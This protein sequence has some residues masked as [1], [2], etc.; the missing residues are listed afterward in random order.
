[1]RSKSILYFI[2][3]V[4]TMAVI[5]AFS[6][7]PLSESVKISNVIVKPVQSGVHT[8]VTAGDEN[9]GS[10]TETKNFNEIDNKIQKLV[11]KT[12]HIFIFGM[13]GMFVFLFFLSINM[14][15]PTAVISTLAFCLFY[16][17]SDEFH[18]H[19]VDSRNSNPRDVCIDMAG[20]LIAVILLCII[21]RIKK[22]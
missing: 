15:I 17:A 11:R 8:A 19:F 7:Q 3:S 4:V 22:K 20:V 12:A 1:M 10:E 21:K 6:S 16:A 5:F 13:L 18:Q 14:R 2:C 9:S